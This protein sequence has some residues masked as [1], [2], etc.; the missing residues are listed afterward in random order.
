M[1]LKLYV[2]PLSQPARALMFF[3]RAAKI[4]VDEEVQI[5]IQ[6]GEQKTEEY[7]KINKFQKVP[8]IVH[9]DFHLAESVA[10]LRYLARTFKVADHWYPQESRGMARVDEFMAWQHL[11]LRSPLTRYILINLMP[12]RLS[13]IPPTAEVIAEHKKAADTALDLFE[14]NWLEGTEF[15]YG[16]EI[17]IADLLAVGEL[18]MLKLAGWNPREGRPKL[19]AYLDRCQAVLQPYWDEVHATLLGAAEFFKNQ[20]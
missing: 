1:V 4:T 3:V 17:S 18:E 13:A 9:D 8:A 7:T 6:K 5:S 2:D 11:G 12:T 19:T 14:K 10:I 20:K 15:I 16:N